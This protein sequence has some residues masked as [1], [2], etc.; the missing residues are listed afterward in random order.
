MSHKN[1]HINELASMLGTEYHVLA[2]MARRGDI[3]CQT[4]RGEFRFNAHRICSWLRQIIP[5]MAHSELIRIDT[6]MSQYRGTSVMPPMVAPLLSEMS[7]MTNLDART[8][9]S[10]KRK[11][12]G[13]A[14]DTQQV[15]DSPT[16]LD[17]LTCSLLP[18]GVAVLHPNQALPYALA[19][20]VVAVAKTRGPVMF[21]HN[22]HAHLFFLCAAPDETHHLH[23]L[24]R[25]CRLGQDPDLLDQLNQAVTPWGMIDALTDV[26]DALL[27]CT[28]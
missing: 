28:S 19:E 3:P 26:E 25:L 1:M 7:V 4:I 23:L 27:A 11:L 9:S 20:P 10:I 17:S 21:S 8:Q 2:R 15:Y 16:L 22:P 12:V 18:S 13:L 6:G 24:A 14:S 5:T